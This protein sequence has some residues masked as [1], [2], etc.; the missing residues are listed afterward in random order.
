MEIV[1]MLKVE[2]V[3][4]PP[5]K[6][7]N[8]NNLVDSE[9][10]EMNRIA[11]AIKMQAATLANKVANGITSCSDFEIQIENEKRITEPKPPPKNT[12]RKLLRFIFYLEFR[13]GKYLNDKT[14]I[15]QPNN[16]PAIQPINTSLGK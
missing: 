6:P 3:L 8:K 2:N 16:P 13:I 12:Q 4:N 5:H 1:S 7:T 14:A 15:I 11:I 9:M 10:G